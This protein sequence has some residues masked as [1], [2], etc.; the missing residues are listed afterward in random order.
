MLQT[1]QGRWRRTWGSRLRRREMLFAY[2]GLLPYIVG[3]LLFLVGP[4]VYSFWLSFTRYKITRPPVVIG[5]EN[6]Q[7]LVKDPL[8]WKS[9]RI[10]ATYAGISVPLGVIIGYSI[11]LLLNQ[12]VRGISLWRTMYYVPSVVPAVATAY[13]FAWLFDARIGL[14]NSL[15]DRIGING[16]NWFGD[17]KWALRT[18]IIMSLWGAGG[19]MVLYLAAMQSVPT[20]LYDASKIDGATAWRRLWAVTIPMT[21]PVILFMLIMG[22]IG[23]FQVFTGIF[24]ITRGGPANATLTYV[25]YLFNNGW[26]YFKMGYAAALAWVLFLI[27]MSLTLLT[28]KLTGRMVYYEGGSG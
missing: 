8:F 25:V 9:L 6:Y 23:S 11:A 5:L 20:E 12:K 3:S 2:A 19:G 28:L 27:I 7:A 26:Q 16:P 18:F 13:L 10:T 14:V 22:I 4:L 24:L 21:S 1:L 15:L 17:P